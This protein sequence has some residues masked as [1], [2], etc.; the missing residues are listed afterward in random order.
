MMLVIN[1]SETKLND[2]KTLGIKRGIKSVDAF[3]SQI[4]DK[5]L[6]AYRSTLESGTIEIP[7][8]DV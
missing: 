3:I 1:I 4:L 7:L 2:L 6:M 8:K 5:E